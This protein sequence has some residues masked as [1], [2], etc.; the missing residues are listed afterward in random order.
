M[1]I[2]LW[3]KT[4]TK[5][6]CLFICLFLRSRLNYWLRDNVNKSNE[7]EMLSVDFIKQ[8]SEAFNV[9]AAYR[10]LNYKEGFFERLENIVCILM[11]NQKKYTCIILGNLNCNLLLNKC[12][13]CSNASIKT[14]CHN[15]SVEPAHNGTN[16]NHAHLKDT[17]WCYLNP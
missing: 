10:P 6:V 9:I 16:K 5:M 7:L 14:I 2:Q 13:Q 12:K 17:H 1:S 11:L 15:L 8:N 4:D 3:R